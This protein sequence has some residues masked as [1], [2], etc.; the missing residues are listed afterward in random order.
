MP[1]EKVRAINNIDIPD[2][3]KAFIEFKQRFYPDV[4]NLPEPTDGLEG[5]ATYYNVALNKKTRKHVLGLFCHGQPAL[6]FTKLDSDEKIIKYILK[7]L[8]A[9]YDGAATANY[10]KHIIQ[11]WAKE[12]FIRGTYSN[13]FGGSSAAEIMAENLNQQ[14]YFAGE[15][16]AGY[17]W[18][19]VHTAAISGRERAEEITRLLRRNI[20]D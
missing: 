19:Y 3:I 5:E 15:A 18:G 7:Q 10:K 13:Y 14:V 2:G 20:K 1:R 16:Y 4:I 9:M 17:D 8:D 12:P 11:N 6:Q